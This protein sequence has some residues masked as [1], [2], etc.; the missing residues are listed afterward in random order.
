MI[1]PTIAAGYVTGLLS[2]VESKGAVR[3]RL[4]EY[5]GIRET[6]LTDHF[7]RIPLTRYITLMRTASIECGDPAL[8][9]HFGESSDCGDLTLI[10]LIGAACATVAEASAHLNRYGRIALDVDGID[11]PDHFPL[12]RERTGVWMVDNRQHHGLYPELTVSSFARFVTNIRKGFPGQRV[13]EVCFSHAA[14][15]YV[16]ECE[17]VFGVPVRFGSRR[18]AIRLDHAFPDARVERAPRYTL[19]VLTAHAD[20]LLRD[21]DAARSITGRV[22]AALLP[23]L[24]T[25]DVSMDRVA[26]A[27]AMSR[28]SLYRALKSEGVTF[29]QLLDRVRHRMALHHLSSRNVTVHQASHLVGFSDPAA[30]SRAFK[31][32]TGQS[33]RA[34]ARAGAA[35]VAS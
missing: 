7:A 13:Q 25:R 11:G 31:R 26:Q 34:A 16:A 29:E 30:F 23:L 5:A 33:P 21:L 19:A 6:E 3:E 28:P 18:S 15:S 35:S 32:W 20:A 27:L 14:P 17:R 12:I 8:A 1:E 9:L 2:F 22:E 4:L 24:S 10:A